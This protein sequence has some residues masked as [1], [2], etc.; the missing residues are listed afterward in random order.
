MKLFLALLVLALVFADGSALK[1]QHCVPVRP[2][3]SCVSGTETCGYKKDTCV[4]AKFEKP[5]SSHFRRCIGMADCL[6]LQSNKYITA[7]CCQRDLCNDI[8]V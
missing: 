3:G 6:L 1:C 5:M 7:N 2:G 4:S 8:I